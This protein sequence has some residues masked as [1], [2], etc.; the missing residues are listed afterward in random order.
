MIYMLAQLGKII[1]FTPALYVIRLKLTIVK[2]P[3]ALALNFH[4]KSRSETILEP[5]LL[6]LWHHFT[7]YQLPF[8]TPE[9]GKYQRCRFHWPKVTNLLSHS[10]FH[11]HTKVECFNVMFAF[12]I[13]S[14]CPWS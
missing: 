11:S 2:Q 13:F 8:I 1:T 9:K 12:N 5:S 3:Q 7:Y 10:L 6:V 14:Q 4:D